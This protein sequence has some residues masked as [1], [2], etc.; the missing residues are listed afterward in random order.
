M[1]KSIAVFAVVALSI[2]AA[3]ADEIVLGAEVALTGPMASFIGPNMRA[4]FE[5]AVDRIN[6]Q[7]LAGDN[8]VKLLV[9]DVASD[10]SQVIA[11]TTRFATVDKVAAI[12]GPATTV[13]GA[14]AAP[15]ANN[16]ATPIIAIAYSTDIVKNNP[17]AYRAYMEAGA[18][19]KAIAAFALNRL[20]VKSA[21]LVFDR[22]NDASKVIDD[23]LKARLTAGG[24]KVLADEGVQQGDTNFGPLATKIV[25]LDPNMLFLATTPEVGANIVVQSRQAGLA[26]ETT[27]IGIGNLASPAYLHTGGQAVWGTYYTSDYSADLPTDENKA[28][29]A[30]YQEKMHVEPDV[31]AA[32]AYASA[33]IVARAIK[34]AGNHPD[35]TKIRDAIG[36]SVDVP[37]VL[38]NG[39]LT[40]GPDHETTY[41][42]AMLRLVEG[43]NELVK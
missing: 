24:V 32:G 21:V 23:D 27:L 28:F 39:K 1:L 20:K 18:S 35:R 40:I 12:L 26:P 33:M 3:R 11:V 7:K 6:S 36:R 22:G 17:W 9:E 5:V 43:K 38:G 34:E 30:A 37:T 15:V 25:A 4:A 14:A 13:L 19:S 31:F 29:V 8:T 41:D 10:K 16:L 42:L 2:S